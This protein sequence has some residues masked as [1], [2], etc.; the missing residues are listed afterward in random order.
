MG[1]KSIKMSNYDFQKLFDFFVRESLKEGEVSL[2][3]EDR[4]VDK[5]KQSIYKF[6]ETEFKMKRGEDEDAVIRMVLSGKNINHFKAVIDR[7]KIE[8]LKAV[9]KRKP[10]IKFEENWNIPEKIE[11]WGEYEKE[12]SK[13]SVMQPFYKKYDSQLEKAFVKFL[14]RS[15][16]IVWWFKNE[17]RDAKFFAIPYDNGEKKPFYI[18]FIVKFKDGRIGLFDTKVGLTKQVAGPKID[19]LYEY[20][21][22][23]NRKGKNL[24]GGI[25]SNTDSQNYRGRWVYFKKT[26]KDFNDSSFENWDDLSLE[27]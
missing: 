26:S 6:F 7:A 15:E 4:S 23:E 24:F 5:I 20:I 8:Y 14:E 25:V 21:Q 18:D 11:Y 3:P 22:S 2:Y 10:E 27:L 13:K 1:D 12:K 16:K 19:G 17:D 9:S